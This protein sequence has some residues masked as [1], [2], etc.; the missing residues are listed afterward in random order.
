MNKLEYIVNDLN[1]NRNIDN[2]IKQIKNI[3]II[4]NKVII[5]NKN[6]I[7]LIQ[8]DIN[9]MINE[10]K[11]LKNNNNIIT[12]KTEIYDNGKYIGEFKNGMRDGKGIYYW[13]NG[14]R[15][16]GDFRNGKYEGKG[17]YY[18]N[19]G[20]RYEGDYRNHKNINNNFKLLFIFNIIFNNIIYS[21]KNISDVTS[22]LA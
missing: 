14:D 17:I 20:E 4:M 10:F 22:P 3:I 12:N 1:N 18:Y 13:N 7:N 8:K 9:N 5:E 21:L 6:N 2:I 16:E 11:E 15:Y 19:N